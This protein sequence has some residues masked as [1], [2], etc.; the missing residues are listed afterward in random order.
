MQEA[1]SQQ[2]L[3]PLQ[4]HFSKPDIEI[5]QKIKEQLEHTGFVFSEIEQDV[6]KVTGI[7]LTLSES[8]AETI[9][10]Q[11]IRLWSGV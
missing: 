4:L 10:Q 2:L 8:Q 11:L 9:L 5:L 6:V 3:F 1:V 7:P